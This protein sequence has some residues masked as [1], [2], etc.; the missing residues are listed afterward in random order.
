MKTSFLLILAILPLACKLLYFKNGPFPA[1]LSFIFGLFQTNINPI[2]QQIDVKNVHPVFCAQIQTHD[3]QN[4][5]L[6]R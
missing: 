4:M 5:S 6:L 3:L 1:S 2:L